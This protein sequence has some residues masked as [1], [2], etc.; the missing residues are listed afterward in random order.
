MCVC[1]RV[2]IDLCMIFFVQYAAKNDSAIPAAT[3]GDKQRKNRNC[4][5]ERC[6]YTC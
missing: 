1:V 5:E 6:R 3:I 2:C 4:L